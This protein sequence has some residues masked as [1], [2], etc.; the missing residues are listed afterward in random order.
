MG[1]RI[2]WRAIGRI[3]LKS[4]LLFVLINLIWAFINPLPA[5]SRLSIHRFIP[6]RERLPFNRTIPTETYSISVFDLDV[7][8]TTHA[9]SRPKLPDEF[10]VILVGDSSVWGAG[11]AADETLAA[12]ISQLHLTTDDGRRVYA[13]NWGFPGSSISKDMLIVSHVKPYDPDLIV[14]LITP[15][16]LFL[17]IQLDSPIL[18][19]N[20]DEFQQMIIKY[21][22][23]LEVEGLSE[24][25]NRFLQRTIIGQRSRI[26]D[27]VRLNV[28]G[29]MWAATRIDEVPPMNDEDDPEGNGNEL[30]SAHVTGME[31]DTLRMI[32]AGI[33]E[34]GDAPVIVVNEPIALSERSSVR[35]GNPAMG[36]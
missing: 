16:S 4:A 28:Y 18:T 21:A 35:S 22:L 17:D 7:T 26:A 13:Y 15:R 19:N 20:S 2:T 31:A 9:I 8:L 11:L 1:N 3:L 10:R 32:S 23:P 30:S 33:A 12:Q 6:A 34:A 27:V 5:L 25:E 24:S 36:R 29:V 14:W